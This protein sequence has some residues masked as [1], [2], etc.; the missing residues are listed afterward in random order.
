MAAP[1]MYHPE[2]L[3]LQDRLRDAQFV[4][5]NNSEPITIVSPMHVDGM[6]LNFW[7]RSLPEAIGWG[8]LLS[9]LVLLVVDNRK[10]LRDFLNS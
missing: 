7:I 9:L 2:I 10:R 8:F 3:A 5:K 1:E 6:K 4:L